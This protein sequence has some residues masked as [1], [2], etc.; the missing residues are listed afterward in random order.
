MVFGEKA[1][2]AAENSNLPAFVI[3]NI[4][5]AK[6]YTEGRTFHTEVGTPE[7]F[8]VVKKLLDIKLNK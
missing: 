1:V 4:L 2:T 3:Q 7:D 5:G 6:E 8:A